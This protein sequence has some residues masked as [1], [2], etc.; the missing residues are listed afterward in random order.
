[1]VIEVEITVDKPFKSEFRSA[2]FSFPVLDDFF[3]DPAESCLAG[4]NGNIAVHFT[5]HFNGFH[6][7]IA[8]GFQAAIEIV[9]FDAAEFP[10]SPV[11]QLAGQILGKGIIIPFFLPPRDQVKFFFRDH[12]VQ[13]REF[14][15]D[16]PAGRH[17]W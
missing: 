9:K 3:P 16:Y 14:H 11:K 10:R 13:D 8:I 5:V 7:I 4:N 15:P 2:K 17:P 6:Y 12:F 1:M